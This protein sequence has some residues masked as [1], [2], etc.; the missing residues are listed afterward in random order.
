MKKI[1]RLLTNICSDN[2]ERSK[3]FYMTLFDLQITFDSDWFVHMT[4]ED[5]NLELGLIASDSDLVPKEFQQQPKGFYI[6]F[7]VDD[8]DELYKIATSANLPVISEPSDT[9]YGQRRLLLKDPSGTLIDISSP[10]K[11]FGM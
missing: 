5:N 8:A 1:D 6:T 2:L 11:D 10:I 9:F 3:K 7:V 4:T